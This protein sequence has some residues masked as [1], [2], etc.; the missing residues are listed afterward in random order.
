MEVSTKHT[1]QTSMPIITAL[2]LTAFACSLEMQLQ[3][4]L[5][6]QATSVFTWQTKT[7]MLYLFPVAVF[8]AGQKFKR[9]FE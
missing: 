3:V 9:R 6:L 1:E 7:H 8:V 4:A 2:T 5:K